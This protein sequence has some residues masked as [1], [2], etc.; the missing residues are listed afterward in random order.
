MKE[1]EDWHSFKFFFLLHQRTLFL[2]KYMYIATL[3]ADFVL[4]FALIYN[5]S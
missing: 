1:K 3:Q 2:K 4:L 5:K